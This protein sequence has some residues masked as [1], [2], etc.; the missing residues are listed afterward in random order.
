MVNVKVSLTIY[1]AAIVLSTQALAAEPFIYPSK[2]QSQQQL[3]K[4]KYEC[5]SWA[6]QNSGFDPGRAQSTASSISPPPSRPTRQGGVFR[7]AVGGAIIGEIADDDA[8]KGAAIGGLIGGIRQRRQREDDYRRQDQYQ[9]QQYQQQ[10]QQSNQQ[11]QARLNY[12]R[13]Y[14]ACLEGRGYTVK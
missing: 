10:Q 5:Y 13:A 7:G 1:L 2:G 8:G 6:K 14:S 12:D 4:D 9:Q 11:S 3:D